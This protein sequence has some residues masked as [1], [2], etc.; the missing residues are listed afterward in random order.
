MPRRWRERGRFG[1]TGIGGARLISDARLE[2]AGPARIA[3]SSSVLESSVR[4]V[5]F[6]LL[7]IVVFAVLAWIAKGAEKL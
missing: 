2:R 1:A 7:T 4:D 5:V 6:V 3:V